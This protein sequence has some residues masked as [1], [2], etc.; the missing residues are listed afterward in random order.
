MKEYKE[1]RRVWTEAH[2]PIPKD[3][4]GRSFEI[5]HINGN[6]QDNRLENLE[7][8]RIEEHFQRHFDNGDWGACVLIGRRMS[9]TPEELSNLQRGKKRPGIGGVPKGTKPWNTGKKGYK[10]RRKTE[11]KEKAVDARFKK[12][13]TGHWERLVELYESEPTIEGVGKTQKNG[14]VLPYDRAFSNKYFSEFP[15]LSTPQSLHRILKNF[16]SFKERASRVCQK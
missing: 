11:N 3:E 5:H 6:H 2:G 15:S 8:L 10:I 1:H 13:W 7:C 14:R 9:M 16:D 4:N 12:V